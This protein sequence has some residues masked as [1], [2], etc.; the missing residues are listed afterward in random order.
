[1]GNFKS[2]QGSDRHISTTRYHCPVELT[3]PP[4]ATATGKETDRRGLHGGRPR[5]SVSLS[6]ETHACMRAHDVNA[7]LSDPIK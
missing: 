5:V 4:P 2:T 1:M 7:A 6:L 3:A